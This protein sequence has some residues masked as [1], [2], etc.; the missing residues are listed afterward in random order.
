MHTLAVTQQVT[1]LAES[2]PTVYDWIF[3]LQLCAD[4]ERLTIEMYVWYTPGVS[5]KK[6]QLFPGLFLSPWWH[7]C[8]VFPHQL[9]VIFIWWYFLVSFGCGG[10][11]YQELVWFDPFHCFHSKGL[12]GSLP[13]YPSLLP[14]IGLC[15]SSQAFS[16]FS[17]WAESH[18]AEMCEGRPKLS[19]AQ[20]CQLS[21]M[22]LPPNDF[23]T[24]T[25]RSPAGVCQLKRGFHCNCPGTNSALVVSF[26]N[27][28]FPRVCF[29]GFLFP[30][31]EF[32]SLHSLCSAY[33][34][35]CERWVM[36]VNCWNQSLRLSQPSVYTGNCGEK[37][38]CD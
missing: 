18:Q 13:A 28:T 26:Q 20:P 24:D 37:T 9:N 10:G 4:S 27:H 38:L 7:V 35:P 30:L 1:T 25:H 17:L 5:W 31:V 21:L 22:P 3:V 16:L 6:E 8:I 36:P 2:S 12:L 23:P 15:W 14:A 34:A 19:S 11:N 33:C 32:L 29:L